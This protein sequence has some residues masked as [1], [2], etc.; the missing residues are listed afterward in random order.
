MDWYTTTE[1][2]PVTKDET[3]IRIGV[4]SEAL[5]W[6]SD[7]VPNPSETLKRCIWRFIWLKGQSGEISRP[8]CE[9]T[10]FE[11]DILNLVAD[12]RK[13]DAAEQVRDSGP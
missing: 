3:K 6:L 10:I 8:M 11:E 9:F 13:I 2:D 5:R 4:T 7:S 12:L 1:I